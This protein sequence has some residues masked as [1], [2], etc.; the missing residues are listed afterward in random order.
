MKLS[1]Y[2]SF[3]I[4]NP[5]QFETIEDFEQELFRL[6]K[7][8]LMID[9]KKDL[10]RYVELLDIPINIYPEFEN[11][12]DLKNLL[13]YVLLNQGLIF[14][15]VKKKYQEQISTEDVEKSV[16]FIENLF[17]FRKLFR[18]N[19]LLDVFRQDP[20]FIENLLLIFDKINF[21][22]I[23]NSDALGTL[24]QKILNGSAR[25]RYAANYT[26]LEP[27][28][29]LSSLSLSPQMKK[30]IDPMGG[31]GRLILTTLESLM[32]N[33]VTLSEA[34]SRLTLNEI[35]LPAV[36]LFF[37][38]LLIRVFK[39]QELSLEIVNK[40]SIIDGDAFTNLDNRPLDI[41]FNRGLDK[42]TDIG[43]FDLVIMNP[44]F[45]RMGLL[46]KSYREFLSN[47]F[48]KY[49]KYINHHMGLHGYALFLAHELLSSNGTIAAVLPASVLYSG[50]G[51]NLKKFLLENYFIKFIISSSVTKALSEDSNFRE[52]IL[53]CQKQKII[54]PNQSVK[55]VT[56]RKHLKDMELAE[57]ASEIVNTDIKQ[58]NKFLKCN[59]VKQSDLNAKK[60]WLFYFES[61]NFQ[62]LYSKLHQNPFLNSD[63]ANFDLVRGFEMYGPNFFLIPNKHWEISNE[64]STVETLRIYKREDPNRSVEIPMK[65]LVKT[66][67][68]PQECKFKL[69]FDTKFYAL[70]VPPGSSLDEN[71]QDYFNWGKD[72]KIPAVS[73]FGENWFNHIFLQ[74]ESKQP[75]GRVFVS[76]KF[77]VSTIR[78]FAYYF[79]EIITATK[80]FYVF[81]TQDEKID[82][83][84]CAWL[85][86]FIF[87][88]LF[89]AERREIGGSYGRLQIEDYKT[90]PLFIKPDRNNNAFDEILVAFHKFQQ[91]NKLPL[92]QEQFSLPERICL[93]SAFL[94]Y[95]GIPPL[96]INEYRSHLYEEIERK[97]Q[98]LGERD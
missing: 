79:P 41:F 62:E 83:F 31:S 9:F 37:L 78:N 63:Q 13:F 81:K 25:K 66:L 27:A 39:S 14:S 15:L 74:L 58:N 29:F 11:E 57:I 44:P 36:Q 26:D 33:E 77:S 55:F 98:N 59:L 32:K 75:F 82:E 89:L 21:A 2:Y 94:K 96:E 52:I 20:E 70:K 49:S 48:K 53:I 45:T 47:C 43:T 54:N 71:L 10:Q 22:M 18:P 91:L 23:S 40:C 61:T 64:T 95:L 93:D 19:V 12:K 7:D 56:L 3:N 51:E 24:L 68:K 88:F 46:E 92:L 1:E 38:K 97:L 73:K 69:T 30:I 80:N 72:S 16:K 87:F 90:T 85:N 34:L 35:F 8:F 17:H 86:S 6:K 67:R 60:N 76:D 65:Y 28:Q 4:H 84:L 5:Q 50:Y 42:K